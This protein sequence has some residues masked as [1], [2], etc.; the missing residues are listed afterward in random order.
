MLLGTF[1]RVE[2]RGNPRKRFTISGRLSVLL[3]QE[4]LLTPLGF[5][6]LPG[7]QLELG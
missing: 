2:T 7:L 4:L 3:V 6:T 1:L 5:L